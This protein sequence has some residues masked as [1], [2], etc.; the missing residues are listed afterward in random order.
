MPTTP[1]GPTTTPMTTEGLARLRLL[2]LASPALPVGAF[3]WSQGLEQAVE[4]GWVHDEASALDWVGGLLTHSQARLDL[5][6]LA[7]L[8]RAWNDD[9][10]VARRY[11][12]AWLRANRETRELRDEDHQLGQALARL[13]DDLGIAEA[14]PLRASD[15]AGFATLFALGASR[16]GLRVEDAL[17][18]YGWAWCENQVMAATK[19]VPL[20]QTAAQRM[21]GA[22]MP[23][24]EEAIIDAL[25]R[26]DD[27]IGTAAPGLALASC[28]H[29]TCYTR[30]FRS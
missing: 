1:A 5:P 21:L 3:A 22:L 9:N 17:R 16:W 13:L 20:G 24:L 23:A 10:V 26:A 27:E 8:Y 28:A 6:V 30:L 2:Q 4:W 29:E 18:G 14:H 25:A 11:W 19:L 15:D 7:R 12:T